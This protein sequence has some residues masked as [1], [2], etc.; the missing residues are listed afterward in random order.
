MWRV[1]ANRHFPNASQPLS[2][3]DISLEVELDGN[4]FSSVSLS[5]GCYGREEEGGNHSKVLGVHHYFL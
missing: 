3:H 5:I 4:I 2:K 1:I